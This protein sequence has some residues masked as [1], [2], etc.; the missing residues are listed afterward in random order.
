MAEPPPVVWHCPLCR[1]AVADDASWLAATEGEE[2]RG[3][4]AR[5][6][7]VLADEDI[8]WGR[9]VRFHNGHFRDRVGSRVYRLTPSAA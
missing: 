6:D 2:A 7:S 9:P 4:S 5:S 3:F 8:A 1:D